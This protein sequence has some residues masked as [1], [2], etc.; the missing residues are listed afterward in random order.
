VGSKTIREKRERAEEGGEVVRWGVDELWRKVQDMDKEMG[1]TG[2]GGEGGG[3][4]GGRIGRR[5]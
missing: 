5:K 2:G 4:G 3:G 1:I